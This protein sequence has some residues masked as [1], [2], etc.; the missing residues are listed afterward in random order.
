[1]IVFA[2]LVGAGFVLG[3]GLHGMDGFPNVIRCVQ[4]RRQHTVRRSTSI[5]VHRADATPQAPNSF[6]S[7]RASLLLSYVFCCPSQWG[8]T[9]ASVESSRCRVARSTELRIRPSNS[10]CPEQGPYP[11]RSYPLSFPSFPFLYSAAAAARDIL[12]GEARSA[13]PRKGFCSVPPGVR[14]RSDPLPRRA[15]GKAALE[16]AALVFG[17]LPKRAREVG[18]REKGRGKLGNESLVGL[19]H[20]TVLVPPRTTNHEPRTARSYKA[21]EQ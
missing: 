7:R 3:G 9:L 12:T 4:Q 19:S 21:D 11:I 20:R 5:S 18:S 8:K 13:R 2:F 6:G 17:A 14:G 16:R 15:R 1:M 10:S